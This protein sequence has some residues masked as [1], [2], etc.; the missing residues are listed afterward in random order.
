MADL[1]LKKKALKLLV[2]NGVLTD[3]ECEKC[4]SAISNDFPIAS[5]ARDTY[6]TTSV[7]SGVIYDDDNITVSYKGLD[8]ITNL[9]YG[10]GYAI[11]FIVE[12]KT[13]HEM[14]VSATEISVNGF[15]IEDDTYIESAVPARRKTINSANIFQ[16]K[17]DDVEVYSI[18]DMETL[19]LRI[20]YE[21]EDLDVEEESEILS[22][23]PY[24]S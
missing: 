24:E 22:L 11:K 3:E 4:I 2:S 8:E 1:E 14:S 7:S 13:S 16:G 10:K 17:L 9:F 6:S 12:N 20:K 18:D 23:T 15:M 19:E 5:I 21:I